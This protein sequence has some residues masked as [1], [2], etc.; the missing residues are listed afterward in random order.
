MRRLL[1]A[2]GVAGLLLRLV[3]ISTA[4]QGEG[5]YPFFELTDE[6]VA[7]I[8]LKDGSIGDWLDVVGEPTLTALDFEA[9]RFWNP[10]NPADMDYRIW[11]AWHDATN[12]IYMAVERADDEYVNDFN[13]ADS[14]DRMA[15]QDNVNFL[16]DGDRSGGR[17]WRESMHFDSE[18]E[19]MLFVNQQA[20][21]YQVLPEVYDE[22]P[23]M[24]MFT[25]AM[26]AEDWPINPPYAEGGGGVFGE[27]PILS[28]TEFYVTSFDYFVW[29]SPEESQVSELYPGKIIGFSIDMADFDTNSALLQ[30]LHAL[31]SREYDD[32]GI[33]WASSDTFVQGYLVRPGGE[34]PDE[35]AVESITWGRIKAQFVK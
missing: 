29:N 11:L 23:N 5:V 16:V 17:F 26:N 14:A 27:N 30:G 18:E 1:I 7:L 32:S 21:Q 20:Q 34:I 4:Q 8:D 31:R 33:D 35:S 12:H 6:D 28:V 15:F 13:R 3:G 19:W 22:G 25:S 2:V 10:Y 24:Q 9:S